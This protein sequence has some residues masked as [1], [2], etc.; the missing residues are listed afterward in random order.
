M[1]TSSHQYA[2]VEGSVV[3]QSHA[4]LDAENRYAGTTCRFRWWRWWWEFSLSLSLSP[5]LP[6]LSYYI[7]DRFYIAL[8]SA[9]QQTH[10][11]HV[12]CDS[13]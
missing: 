5:C 6:L 11:A 13:E 12:T 7:I 2:S 8:F 9:L 4:S 3:S 10:R 1:Q